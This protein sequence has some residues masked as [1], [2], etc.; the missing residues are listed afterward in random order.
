[1][2]AIRWI[3]T[4]AVLALSSGAFAGERPTAE[5]L[6]AA[7]QKSFE[8][9]AR[10]RIECTET[11]PKQADKGDPDETRD[12][13]ILR[14]ASRWKLDEIRR[15]K[16]LINGNLSEFGFWNQTLVADEIIEAALHRLPPQDPQER[17]HVIALRD[18]HPRRVWTRLYLPSVLFGYMPGDGGFPLWM[19]MGEDTKLELLPE[20]EKIAGIE[21]WVLKSRGKYGE[22][23]V[24]FDPASDGLPRRI[25]IRKQFG[26]L[27]NDE[28]LGSRPPEESVPTKAKRGQPRPPSARQDVFTR[29]DNIQIDNKNGVFLITAF[30]YKHRF[31]YVKTQKEIESRRELRVRAI[32]VDPKSWPEDAFQFDIKIPNEL[33]VGIFINAPLEFGSAVA[34]TYE[35]WIDGKLQKRPGQ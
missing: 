33:S 34:D 16:R 4:A 28:Q 9:L 23:K 35:E 5:E 19:V 24:W 18:N 26:D 11:D 10:V 30:D 1:M 12:L 25:E 21:T 14:D 17:P 22:H 15:G 8:K 31:K 2:N 20:P 29:I 3:L 32:D 27:L 6:L 13:T 7:C